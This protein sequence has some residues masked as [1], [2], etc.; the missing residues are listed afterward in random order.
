MISN[1]MTRWLTEAFGEFDY[2]QETENYSFRLQDFTDSEIKKAVTDNSI[3]S[4][5]Q[6]REFLIQASEDEE[7]IAHLWGDKSTEAR[8]QSIE[9]IRKMQENLM[10]VSAPK[11]DDQAEIED[12]LGKLWQTI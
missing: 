6:L 1:K 3:R 8:Q 2:P 4:W 10:L 5:W 7:V 11:K 12:M 9:Q